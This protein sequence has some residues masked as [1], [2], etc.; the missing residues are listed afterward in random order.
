MKKIGVTLTVL[1]LFACGPTKN[2]S[3]KKPLFE[4]LTQQNEGGASIRFFEILTEE[5]EIKMLQNDENL[6]KKIKPDDI[7]K[8]NFVILNLGEKNSGG[9]SITVEKAEE[10]A[11]Q[12]II[13][14]KENKPA[15]GDMVMTV[16]SYPY[17][18][19]KINSKKEIVIRDAN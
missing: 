2:D 14:V 13:T 3:A 7:N 8:A 6:Q 15:Q 5:K 19:V 1:L 9:Y 12:I 4:V 18:I 10:T 11:S 17:T 16:M